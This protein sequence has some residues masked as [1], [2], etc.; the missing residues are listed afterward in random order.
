[1][2]RLFWLLLRWEK[3]TVFAFIQQHTL[4]C[5]GLQEIWMVL[6]QMDGPLLFFAIEENCLFESQITYTGF[7]AFD[8]IHPMDGVVYLS[9]NGVHFSLYNFRYTESHNCQPIREYCAN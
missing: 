3:E 8:D 1:M 2:A 5:I 4:N 9:C 7:S 6:L